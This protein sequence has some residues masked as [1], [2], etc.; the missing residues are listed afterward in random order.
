MFSFQD[1]IKAMGQLILVKIIQAII[2]IQNKLE[3]KS[4]GK[5]PISDC[6]ECSGY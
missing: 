5:G 4:Y 1:K 2:A 3:E 6:W